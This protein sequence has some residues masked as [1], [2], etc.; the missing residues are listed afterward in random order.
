MKQPLRRVVPAAV[1]IVPVGL[2]AVLWL[3]AA[4]SFAAARA[5]AQ[6]ENGMV[7]TSQAD[8]TEAGLAMLEAGGNAVDAAVAAAFAVGVTQPFSAGIG[9]GG[10]LLIRL[11]DGRVVA[12]DARETAPTAATRTMYVE[13]GVPE[14]ASV[15]GPLAVATPGWVA[16]LALALEE[17]GTLPLATV[18]APAIRLAGEGFPIG[19]YH[20][21]M[22]E[23]MRVRL[24]KERF[25]ETVRIQF[26]PDGEKAVPG[27]R[28]VQKDL[29][30]TLR[31]IAAEGPKGFYEGPVADGIVDVM[32]AQWRIGH[33]RRLA[34]L[35]TRHARTRP[36]ALPRCRRVLVPAAV[37]GGRDPDRDP[38]HP[39][40]VRP[41][42]ARPGHARAGM[43]LVSRGHEAGLRRPRGLPG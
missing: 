33:P 28:L 16:G 23:A 18:L 26:P 25:P 19:P 24:T 27:W 22:I 40:W 30:N 29:A 2:A 8:A 11:P 38:E 37:V 15:W 14:R 42:R 4:A 1:W 35:H 12:V 6:G 5:P 21:R 41:G 34:G 7:V 43:H 10:F 13:P 20:A 9:G 36:R 31:R 3:D 32:K 39:R 17:H